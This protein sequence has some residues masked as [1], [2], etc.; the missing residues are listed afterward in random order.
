[1]FAAAGE[2]HELVAGQ[3]LARPL[4]HRGE[5]GEFARGQLQRFIAAPQF[6]GTEV[7]HEGA[8]ADALAGC[9][10]GTGR[11][12]TAAQD[13]ADAGN[14]LARIAGLGQV[15]VGA[16]L[17]TDDAVDVVAPGRQHDDR[18]FDPRSAQAPADR[19]AILARQHQVEHD[20]VDVAAHELSV[21]RGSITDG[22]GDEALLLEIAHEQLAQSR[23]VIDDQDPGLTVCVAHAFI[24]RHSRRIVATRRAPRM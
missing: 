9:L 19:Q 16:D 24:L 3:R 1:M 14:E 4:D 22:R 23:I 5:H 7:E 6:A 15:V 10:R 20:Q 2:A 12:A 17:E 13:R 18:R 21:E 11:C 8:E